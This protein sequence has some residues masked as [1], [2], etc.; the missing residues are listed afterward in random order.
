MIIHFIIMV[1]RK[2]IILYY[3]SLL[4]EIK[5]EKSTTTKKGQLTI[6]TYAPDTS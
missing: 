1:S 3:H 5:I 6:Q 4:I 2:K